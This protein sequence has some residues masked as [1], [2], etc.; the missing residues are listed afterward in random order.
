MEGRNQHLS[1]LQVSQRLKIPKHTLRFWE[2]ELDGLLVPLRTKGGQRRYTAENLA[3][4]ED[5]KR[6]RNA[7]LGLPAIRGRIGHAYEVED[8]Q[9][10]KI[11]ILAARIAEA[12]KTEV[13]NFLKL[14]K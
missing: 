8:I 1:I 11:A 7:G 12:V 6:Y 2:K 3:V 10:I 4:L 14:E 13:Y 9:P 5:I